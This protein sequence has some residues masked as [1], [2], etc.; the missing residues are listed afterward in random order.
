MT[1]APRFA[2]R[3]VI[4]HRALEGAG[5]GHGFG[6]AV[7]LAYYVEEPRAT[8]DIDL[9]IAVPVDRAQ[10]VLEALPEG[11]VVGRDAA[12]SVRRD[13]QVRLWWDGQ[14]G[15]PV[16]LFFPQHDFHRVVARDTTSVPFLDTTIPIISATHLTVFK[17]L[18]NRPRDWPDIAAMLQAGTVDLPVALQW[19]GDLLGQESAPF[20]K[21][22]G[23]G[24]GLV[25]RDPGGPEEPPVIDWSSFGS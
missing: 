13:G 4:L 12:A 23:L 17:C 2:Q 5:I 9:N 21:L 11:I 19:V 24:E 15:I 25:Y 20:L 22:A 8:R 1:A 10:R 3:I 18:F 6:G 14:S 7:A 16:D